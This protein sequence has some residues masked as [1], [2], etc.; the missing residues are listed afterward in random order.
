M[1]KKTLMYSQWITAG[2]WCLLSLCGTYPPPTPPRASAAIPL[3]FSID[4][5]RGS[6]IIRHRYW[7]T[8]LAPKPMAL[9]VYIYMH[10]H[11]HMCVCVCVT[12][13]INVYR[14]VIG[15]FYPFCIRDIYIYIY[16]YTVGAIGFGAKIVRQY[17]WRIIKDPL[18]SPKENGNGI[19]A[20]ARGGVGRA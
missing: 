18:Y 3:P 16:I 2:I 13:G 8:I 17:L 11:T 15:L 10:T 7:R 6:L 19:G 14:R 20:L 9:T 1:T 4:G 5:Y 12:V